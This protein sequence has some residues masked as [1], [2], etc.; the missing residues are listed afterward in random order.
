MLL[1]EG[2]VALGRI[3]PRLRG[4]LR[5]K[6]VEQDPVFVGGPHGAVLAQK[7]RASALLAPEAEVARE[8]PVHEVLE[9]D[10][11]FHEAPIDRRGHAIDHRARHERLAHGSSGPLARGEQVFDGHREVVVR[12]H[13][14][15]ARDDAVSIEVGVIAKGDVEAILE[16]DQPRHRVGGRAVHANAAV[17]ID[18]HEGKRGIHLLADHLEIEPVGLGDRRP[19]RDA[20]AAHGVDADLQT[21][22]ADGLHVQHVSELRYVGRDVV[23]RCHP[24]ARFAERDPLDAVEPGL[25]QCVRATLDGLGLVTRRRAPVRWV[26]FD[27]AVLGRVVA[28]R[29]DDAVRQTLGASGVVLQDRMGDSGSRRVATRRVDEDLHAIADQHLQH[30]PERGRAQRVRV[31]SHVERAGDPLRRAVLRDGLRDRQDV[32]LVEARPQRAPAM[33]ARPERDAMRAL[34]GVGCVGVVRADQRRDVDE[35][36]VRRGL[37]GERVRHGAQ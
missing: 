11:D 22:R 28:R 13:Q 15:G 32:R 35:D 27:A 10:R 33:S 12:V 3:A 17:A 37:S 25:E 21:R 14:P 26:V 23:E 8:Q 6:Q 18:A 31:A 24:R 20:R 7:A 29:D 30:G 19:V 9:A 36:R 5:R 4:D 34:C 1:G 2:G 16:L